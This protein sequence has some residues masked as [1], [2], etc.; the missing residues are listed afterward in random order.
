M[1]KI[2]FV[3]LFAALLFVGCL[4]APEPTPNLDEIV[5]A[6][7]QAL[8]L[9]AI[10]DAQPTATALP[11]SDSLTA[12]I[13]TF[14][15]IASG[16]IAGNLSYPSN[17]IPSQ[18]VVAFA[19]NS[20]SYYYVITNENQNTYQIDNLP[21]GNY[22]VVAYL[23]DGSLSA[24]YSQAVLCGLSVECT[25]N[26]LIAVPVTSGQVTNNINPQDWYAPLGSFPANPLP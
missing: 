2:L 11:I 21:P 15:P 20:Q 13:P 10:Q 5:Q 23:Q 22:Y 19:V 17:F 12:G 3:L 14:T 7:F 4:S 6:T 1:K 16:S 26:S 18:V 9:Q 24:G 25:N 8:T